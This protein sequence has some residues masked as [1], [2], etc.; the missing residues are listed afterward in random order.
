[1]VSPFDHFYMREA[2]KRGNP[3]KIAEEIRALELEHPRRPKE[4]F[5]AKM[6]ELNKKLEDCLL[7]YKRANSEIFNLSKALDNELEV[8][9][10]LGSLSTI[11]KQDLGGL[12]QADLEVAPE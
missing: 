9:I 6:D 5:D 8:S 10:D 11:Q 1:M 2:V 3:E 12:S 4:E 7:N